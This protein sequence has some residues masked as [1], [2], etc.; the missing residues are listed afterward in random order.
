[1][2]LFRTFLNLLLS[3]FAASFAC[4]F[5]LPYNTDYQTQESEKR[6][7]NAY[8][9]DENKRHDGYNPNRLPQENYYK[10]VEHPERYRN[11]NPNAS[12]QGT[13]ENPYNTKMGG[14][15]RIKPK[16]AQESNPVY[17]SPLEP[18]PK[19]ETEEEP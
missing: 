19:L 12:P 10:P 9:L 13:Y 16:D 17:S 18:I 11:Y 4:A 14:Y 1:M 15:S 3:L 8:N 6:D 7:R 5:D 2:T